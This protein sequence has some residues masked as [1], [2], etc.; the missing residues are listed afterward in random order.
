MQAREPLQGRRVARIRD[1]DALF[2]LSAAL[3]LLVLHLP[4]ALQRSQESCAACLGPT[5]ESLSMAWIQLSSWKFC[6][7]LIPNQFYLRTTDLL[8]V[9][10][11]ATSSLP[12]MD[13]SFA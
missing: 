13:P 5:F 11:I 4:L 10:M 8:S 7:V 1:K 3:V 2:S 12:T 9:R 6:L